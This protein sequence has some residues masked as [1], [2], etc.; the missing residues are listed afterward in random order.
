MF[1]CIL[2]VSWL[3]SKTTFEIPNWKGVGWRGAK[4][5]YLKNIP[6]CIWWIVRKERN[7]RWVASA[8]LIIS[9]NK[10]CWGSR[11]FSWLHWETVQFVDIIEEYAPCLL[12]VVSYHFVIFCLKNFNVS[13]LSSILTSYWFFRPSGVY[14]SILIIT[15]VQK[16][17][18]YWMV[19]I[20]HIF[21]YLCSLLHLQIV[22]EL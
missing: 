9:V 5:D 10:I 19:I 22:P 12:W 15:L 14:F 18:V 6:A 11:S 17:L 21:T 7:A 8:L 4:K 3:T 13:V 1:L 16:L 20:W 2:G